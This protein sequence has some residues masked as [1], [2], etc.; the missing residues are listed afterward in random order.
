MSLKLFG[1]MAPLALGGMWATGMIGGGA[2]SRDVDR[3]PSQVMAALGDLDVREQPGSP[4][5]DPARS[6]GLPH[7]ARRE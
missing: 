4:G 1:I 5:T 7:R 2:Y 6:G 3:T